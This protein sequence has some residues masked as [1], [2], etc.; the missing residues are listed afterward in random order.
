MLDMSATKRQS[1]SRKPFQYFTLFLVKSL[2]LPS[3]DELCVNK[4]KTLFNMHLKEYYISRFHS[5]VHR[6]LK[7]YGNF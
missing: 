4:H 3:S 6:V 7:L 2:I 1:H 5:N